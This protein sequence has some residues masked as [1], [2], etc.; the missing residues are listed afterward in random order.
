VPIVEQELLTLQCSPAVFSGV[1]ESH[2]R[3]KDKVGKRKSIYDK[4]NTPVVI[5][6][7]DIP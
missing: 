6:D 3:E 2:E 1:R 5:C 7:P 4:W